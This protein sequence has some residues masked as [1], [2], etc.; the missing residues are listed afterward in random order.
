[1]CC[2]IVAGGEATSESDEEDARALRHAK[3]RLIKDEIGHSKVSVCMGVCCCSGCQL[4]RTVV[5]AP[6]VE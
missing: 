5:Q 6:G 1:M 3:H 4:Y 2:C